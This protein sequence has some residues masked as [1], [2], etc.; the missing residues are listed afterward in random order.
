MAAAGEAVLEVRD[1]QKSFGATRALVGASIE[2]KAGEVHVLLGENGSGKSTL[3]KV[4]A[5]IHAAD[6]GTISVNGEPVAFSDARASRAHGIAIV[7][8]ELSLAPELSV[9]DNLF[10]GREGAAHPLSLI[11]I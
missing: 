8:Q 2:V 11:H 3:A 1:L 10:L 6:G 5:G 9:A 4:V 7:F